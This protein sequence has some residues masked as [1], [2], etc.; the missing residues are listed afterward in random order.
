MAIISEENLMV[1]GYDLKLVRAEMEISN[2]Y[3][4]L[5]MTADMFFSFC[6]END[7]KA[8]FY[9]FSY[10]NREEYLISEELLQKYTDNKAEYGYCKKWA[11]SRNAE[12]EM[13][14]FSNAWCL[15]MAAVLDSMIL[16]WQE[17]DEWIP[18]NTE[19]A[20]DAL[21]SF[22]EEHEDDM[23][24]MFESDEDGLTLMDEFRETLLADSAFRYSTNKESRRTYI[25]AFLK[26]K[27]NKK[28]LKLVRKE[29]E[30]FEKQYRL[31]IIVDQIYNEYRNNCYRA[32][33]Q[34]GEMPPKNE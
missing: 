27:D 10:Y 28:F 8:V 22:Q 31:G 1:L 29:K 26:K 11:V 25:Q 30:G 20:E 19:K 17:R 34:V 32:K 24:D 23:L 6:R 12:I 33:V 21:I 3:V 9:H 7:I 16:L 18:E 15:T 5:N 13:L 2:N 14:D 4:I